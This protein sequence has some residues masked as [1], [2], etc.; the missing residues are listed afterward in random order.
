MRELRIDGFHLRMEPD[1]EDGGEWI[2]L[3]YNQTRLREIY[4]PIRMRHRMFDAAMEILSDAI[5]VL[6]PR[7]PDDFFKDFSG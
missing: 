1:K 5:E 2:T 3:A 6:H 4:A 7:L